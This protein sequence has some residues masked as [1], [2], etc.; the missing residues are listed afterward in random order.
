MKGGGEGKARAAAEATQQASQV[1]EPALPLGT[2]PRQ[3]RAERSEGSAYDTTRTFRQ[4]WRRRLQDQKKQINQNR[5]GNMAAK[6]Q[7]VDAGN[8]APAAKLPGAVASGSAPPP[9]EQNGQDGP[10]RGPES[11]RTVRID[12]FDAQ[13]PGR[14]A[15]HAQ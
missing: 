8:Q 1:V 12:F 3:K 13:A 4:R 6:V 9:A 5:D 11:R 14:F 7:A 2:P 10:T 15:G